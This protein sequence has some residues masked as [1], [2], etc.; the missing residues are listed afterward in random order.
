MMTL[1]SLAMI[2]DYSMI[3]LFE[4]Y[5]LVGV[6]SIVLVL[7]D[8]KTLLLLN[9]GLLSVKIFQIKY[10]SSSMIKLVKF[11]LYMSLI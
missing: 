11:I 6:L 10:C 7:I 5:T 4:D 9:S 2:R 1:L 8:Y 3:E